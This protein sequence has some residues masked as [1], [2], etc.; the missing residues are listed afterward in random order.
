MNSSYVVEHEQ[1]DGRKWVTETHIDDVG[2]RH[3]ARYL[4]DRNTD[5][6]AILSARATEIADRLVNEE[7]E[8]VLSG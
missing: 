7:I 4:A 1:R 5:Y 8:R 6:D 3:V 2:E